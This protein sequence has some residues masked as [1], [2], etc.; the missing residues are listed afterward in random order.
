[1]LYSKVTVM[2]V[3]LSHHRHTGRM[4]PHNETS[5]ALLVF[6]LIL[7]SLIVA[8]VTTPTQAALNGSG[9]YTVLAVVPGPRPTQP[10]IITSPVNGQTFQTNPITVLGTCPRGTL[11]KIFKNGVLAGSIICDSTGHFNLPID[12]LIGANALTAI[13]YNTNDQ[14]GPESPAVNV[15]LNVPAGGFGFSSELLLQSTSYYRG[16]V[17]GQQVV[18]P[19]VIVGGLAPYA[20][21]FDWG[22][23]TSSLVTRLG[24]GPFDLDHVYHQPGGYLGA[25]PLIIRATDTAG[26][27]AYLQLTTIVNDPTAST[28]S[29]TKGGNSFDLSKIMIIWP[30]LILLVL[31]VLAFWLGERREKVIMQREMAALA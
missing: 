23:T 11:V 19:I 2:V 16:V 4:R 15:T 7:T 14:S 13:A 22:D 17:V 12:L 24:P 20:V 10:A 29:T 3:K 5:Y 6:L 1:M 8:A 25:F 9:T 18:W 26:H 28:S 27:T 30:I 31:V 21:N